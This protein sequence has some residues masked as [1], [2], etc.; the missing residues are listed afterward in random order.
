MYIISLLREIGRYFWK[1]K[2]VLFFF[3]FAVLVGATNIFGF[4]DQPAHKS[5]VLSSLVFTFGYTIAVYRYGYNIHL[6]TFS[7]N[8]DWTLILIFIFSLLFSVV[9]W[10]FHQHFRQKSDSIDITNSP[11]EENIEAKNASKKKYSDLSNSFRSTV[12]MSDLP[13]TMGSLVLVIY[14]FS[15]SY[16]IQMDYFFSGAIAFQMMA[17]N[18]I[19]IFNDDIF[20][21]SL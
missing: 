6:F 20:F 21:E 3:F 10:A 11:N 8:R 13:V 12:F 7:P 14:S 18:G 16:C 4:S 9:N 17:S 19:W 2:C 15:I 1:N 5:W